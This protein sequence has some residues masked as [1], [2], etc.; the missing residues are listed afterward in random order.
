MPLNSIMR[1]D[2]K[3][4]SC[5]FHVLGYPG[6]ALVRKLVS[7]DV[8]YPWFLLGTFLCLPFHIWLSLVLVGLAVSDSNMSL[9][10]S[11]KP[12]AALLRDQLSPGKTSA[13]R[14][15]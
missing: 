14:A 7:D 10:S 8:M 15:V 13:Q 12:V 3:S 9:L 11:C 4:K 6:L 2:F 1:C 5:V